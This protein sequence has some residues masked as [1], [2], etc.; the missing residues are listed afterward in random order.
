MSQETYACENERVPGGRGIIFRSDH[1][2]RFINQ[3]HLP[4]TWSVATVSPRFY[5]V[6]RCFSGGGQKRIVT[7]K[8]SEII[9]YSLRPNS[10]Y[11]NFRTNCTPI[12][13]QNFETYLISIIILIH[14]RV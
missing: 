13:F 4:F 11:P 9:Q 10:S 1:S 3:G 2:H 8:G 7:A 5:Y 14:R 6:N 12:S